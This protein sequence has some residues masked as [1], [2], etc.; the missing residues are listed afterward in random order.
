MS[1]VRDS[2]GGSSVDSVVRR[3]VLVY[4]VYI[5]IFINNSHGH[6]NYFKL[7]SRSHA[8]S[9]EYVL[10]LAKRFLQWSTL[11]KET[12]IEWNAYSLSPYSKRYP[13]CHFEG[14]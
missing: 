6:P 12:N 9:L 1:I 11:Q 5:Y 7:S 2:H 14:L 8:A 3:K 10:D 13:T 4:E